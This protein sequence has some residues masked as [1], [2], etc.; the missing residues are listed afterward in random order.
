M[1]TP[2]SKKRYVTLT[3][4]HLKSL[5]LEITSHAVIVP[6][7]LIDMRASSVAMA[8]EPVWMLQ[9][10][11]QQRNDPEINIQLKTA[12]QRLRLAIQMR[13]QV[14]SGEICRVVPVLDSTVVPTLYEGMA[15]MAAPNMPSFTF[16]KVHII[17]S[18]VVCGALVSLIK[19]T[20]P[21]YNSV[22]QEGTDFDQE[23]PLLDAG[24]TSSMSE[25]EAQ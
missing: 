25:L 12:Q 19:D 21:E 3:M 9:P 14:P 18:R 20:F 13:V 22:I 8:P 23:L 7:V 15:S 17:A 2:P 16:D 11:I 24:Y 5:N 4:Q 10:H 1:H 6:E